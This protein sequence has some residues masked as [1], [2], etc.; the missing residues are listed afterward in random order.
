MTVERSLDL[1]WS[2]VPRRVLTEL[3]RTDP[4]HAHHIDYVDRPV[5]PDEPIHLPSDV[6][7]R[8]LSNGRRRVV[9]D[10]VAAL[11]ASEET[12]IGDLAVRIAA[13]ENDIDLNRVTSEQRKSAYVSLLQCHLPK[14]DDAGVVSWDRRSGAVSRGA[15][16][17]ELAD[18]IG[19]IE[20]VC[21]R[22]RTA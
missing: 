14:L 16:I 12:T 15:S 20:R 2:S 19:A 22:E 13:V 3:V 8:L 6:V 21:S 4:D 17:D 1:P 10:E 5:P 11:D 18:L 9:I 7:C